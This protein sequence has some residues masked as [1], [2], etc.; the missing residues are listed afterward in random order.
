MI[1][2]MS[3]D[4]FS[5][6]QLHENTSPMKSS[7]TYLSVIFVSLR[8]MKPKQDGLSKSRRARVGGFA[9]H[10]EE[11]MLV[12]VHSLMGKRDDMVIRMKS[13]RLLM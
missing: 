2:H 5:R 3:I 4:N 10:P 11:R 9:V 8:L 7:N 1:M 6:L 13:G 12:L